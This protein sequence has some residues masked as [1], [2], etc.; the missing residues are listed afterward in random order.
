VNAELAGQLVCD[1]YIGVMIRWAALGQSAFPLKQRL[2]A[3]CAMI[4]DGLRRLL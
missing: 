3:V 4:L 2:R 1:V